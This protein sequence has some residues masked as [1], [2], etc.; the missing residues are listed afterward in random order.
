MKTKITLLV[1]SSSLVLATPVLLAQN[2]NTN[3][4]PLLT[5][6]NAVPLKE[7]S[8][9]QAAL[10][11]DR[12]LGQRGMLP[13]GVKE[14]M[15]LTNAQRTELKAFEDDFANT[16]KQYQAANQ[17]RIDAAQESNRRARALKDPAQ[18]RA[19]RK[20]LHDIWVGLQRD[21]EAAVYRI[22]PLLTPDQIKVLEDT[23][24]QWREN[25]DDEM[26]DPSAN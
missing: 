9:Y 26:N 13:P 8:K 2:T 1:I 22:K 24:N 14:K 21:R 20:Q 4:L 6:T 18:I 10:E 7:T 12:S 3:A 11:N 19:T 17:S 15:K 16:S 23:K 25:D 5:N